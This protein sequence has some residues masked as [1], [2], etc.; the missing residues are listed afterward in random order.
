MK[1]IELFAISLQY[2]C[3]HACMDGFMFVCMHV[4]YIHVE[5]GV[6]RVAKG[7]DDSMKNVSACYQLDQL[8]C[9]Y[10]ILFA[11]MPDPALALIVMLLALHEGAARRC[12][13]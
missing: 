3:M 2:V 1:K 13:P 4:C 10:L 5:I 12:L 11:E 8:H 9:I 7:R 6:T